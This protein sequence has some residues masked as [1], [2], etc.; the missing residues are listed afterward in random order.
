MRVGGSECGFSL[1]L[2]G[3]LGEL[4]S[5]SVL[6][7]TV[8]GSVPA[9]VGGASDYFTLPLVLFSADE[10]GGDALSPDAH[11]AGVCDGG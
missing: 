2:I 9:L 4:V 8:V 5:F 10:V 11:E 6:D 7:V 1:S 3:G